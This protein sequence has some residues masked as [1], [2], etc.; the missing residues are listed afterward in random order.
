MENEGLSVSYTAALMY[1]FCF[2]IF[3]TGMCKNIILYSFK[4]TVSR[5]WIG[6][7]I[8]LMDKPKQAHVSH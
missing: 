2:A 8:W 6:P 3:C 1:G 5:D 7:C 4:G